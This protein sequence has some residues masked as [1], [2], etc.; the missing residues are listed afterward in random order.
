MTQKGTDGVCAHATIMSSLVTNCNMCTVHQADNLASQQQQKTGN[1][2]SLH[3]DKSTDQQRQKKERWGKKDIRE[4]GSQTMGLGVDEATE[5]GGGAY[6]PCCH[7]YCTA[8]LGGQG[9]RGP[10]GPDHRATVPQG[11]RDGHQG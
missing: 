6:P 2:R 10:S 3:E 4:K 7:Q 5:S 11:E 8:E 1:E 9:D